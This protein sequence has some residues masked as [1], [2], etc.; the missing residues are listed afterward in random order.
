[1][2]I[3][4][5]VCG[6]TANRKPREVKAV[7]YCSQACWYQSKQPRPERR[8]G[9]SQTCPVC[10]TTFYVCKAR[11]GTSVYCSMKC[12]GIASRKPFTCEE[13]GQQVKTGF[14]SR[15]KRWCSRDC[16]A[17]ARRR[18]ADFACEECGQVFTAPPSRLRARFCSPTCHNEWQGR[19][20]VSGE[21]RV[22]GR[23]FRVSPSLAN[24]L[25]CS[26]ACRDADP[27]RRAALLDMNAKQAYAYPN[28]LEQTGYSLLD[29]LGVPYVRQ[30]AFA[31]KFVV[32]AAYAPVLVVIQFDGDYWHDREGTSE[33]PRVLRRAALD[34][35][36]DNYMRACGW[37]V[38]R[39]WESDIRTAPA[40]CAERV[41][42][43]VFPAS[44]VQP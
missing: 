10:G 1:M 39:L 11:V 12:K 30:Y 15:S 20:K 9:L 31:D 5:A 34:H 19:N 17:I 27:V 4:C 43:H 35:S 26:L 25:Y 44:P 41:R 8:T 13:C 38:L 6:A 36:Q 28:R 33:E 40:T 21:C 24:R 22:C 14:Q 42:A 32:D 29:G 23:A 7:N 16:A 18:Q 37:R 3:S 2:V